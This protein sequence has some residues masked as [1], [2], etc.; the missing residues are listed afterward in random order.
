MPDPARELA[1]QRGE[2]EAVAA[3][4]ATG[5]TRSAAPCADDARGSLNGPDARLGARRAQRFC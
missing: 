4:M 3:V 1:G 5:V 2:D